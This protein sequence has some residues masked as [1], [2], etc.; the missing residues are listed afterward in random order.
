MKVWE[1]ALIPAIVS[2][3]SST[4]IGLLSFEGWRER[5]MWSGRWAGIDDAVWRAAFNAWQSSKSK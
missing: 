1:K 3:V 5:V 2:V 4:L